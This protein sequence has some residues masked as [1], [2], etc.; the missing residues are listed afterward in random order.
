MQ[1]YGMDAFIRIIAHLLFIYLSFWTLQSLRIDQFFKVQHV[2]QIRVLLI[3]TAIVLGYTA[4]SFFLEFIALCRN[5]F[6]S[7]FP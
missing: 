2:S 4:S 6:L 5:I 7:I 3:L 1:Y